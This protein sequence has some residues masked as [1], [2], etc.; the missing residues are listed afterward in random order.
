MFYTCLLHGFA[1]FTKGVTPAGWC[2]PFTAQRRSSEGLLLLWGILQKNLALLECGHSLCLQLCPAWEG[3]QQLWSLP[4]SQLL[5]QREISLPLICPV[6]TKRAFMP[7]CLA[8]LTY[9][10][11]SI[12]S[13]SRCSDLHKDCSRREQLTKEY[14]QL[15]T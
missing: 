7:S 15:I 11:G 8:G 10:S 3:Q 13:S 9:P 2:G 5:W 6:M 1:S 4:A 12:L 14:F